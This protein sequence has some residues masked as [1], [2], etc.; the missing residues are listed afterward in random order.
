MSVEQL[1]EFKELI[2]ELEKPVNEATVDG[3]YTFSSNG[4]E[5]ETSDDLDELIK[6]AEEYV[7]ANLDQYDEWNIVDNS[8]GEVMVDSEEGFAGGVDEPKDPE[9]ENDTFD[10]LTDAERMSKVLSTVEPMVAD[11]AADVDGSAYEQA[12]SI[13]TMVTDVMHDNDWN[14]YVDPYDVM[15]ELGFDMDALENQDRDDK[16]SAEEERVSSRKASWGEM[17][18]QLSDAEKNA[19]QEIESQYQS[20]Y[21]DMYGMDVGSIAEEVLRRIDDEGIQID[22]DQVSLDKMAFAQHVLSNWEGVT[23]EAKEIK[24]QEQSLEEAYTKWKQEK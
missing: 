7:D 17:P 13:M 1:S 5:V 23:T 21:Q 15:Y 24:A 14:R 19:K 3:D 8:S 2:R 18:S 6:T 4:V 20:I 16:A 12:D 10:Q 9:P 22:W 11:A